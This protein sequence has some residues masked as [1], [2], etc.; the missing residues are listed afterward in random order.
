M[1]RLRVRATQKRDPGGVMRD[2][3]GCGSSAA[4]SAAA[5][6]KRGTRRFQKGDG[7]AGGSSSFANGGRPWS[8][9]VTLS[10]TAAMTSLP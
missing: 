2:Q 7:G 9:A 10:P 6:P 5:T 3:D 1:I 8:P 4:A